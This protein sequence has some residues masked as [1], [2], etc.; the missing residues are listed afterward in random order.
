M[1]KID[2]Y[3][4]VLSPFTYLAGARLESLAQKHELAIRYKPFDIMALFSK[5]GGLP[6][7]KRHVSRQRYRLAELSRISQ[8]NAMPIRLHPKF[9]PTDPVPASCSII[10]SL[11]SSG[12]TGLLVR[13]ILASCW[14]RDK[15]IAKI[16][17]IRQCLSAAGFDPQL[18]DADQSGARETFFRNTRQAER[19]DVFGSPAYV[20]NGEVFWGQDRLD[21]LNAALDGRISTKAG[22]I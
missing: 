16:E 19:D 9:W 4:S 20:L 22:R 3:F 7:G 12:D 10:N 18:A 11:N 5:T 17:V 13:E 14:A 6:P 15:D 2:Y 1:M 21:H 8:L